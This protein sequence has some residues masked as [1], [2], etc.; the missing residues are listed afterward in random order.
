MRCI[1]GNKWK[2]SYVCVLSAPQ[3]RQFYTAPTLLRSLMQTGDKWVQQ[4]DRSSLRVLGTVGE[5]IGEHAW[6]WFGAHA[7]GSP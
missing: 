4:H 2:C 6:N 7:A 3:V 5:P 1:V